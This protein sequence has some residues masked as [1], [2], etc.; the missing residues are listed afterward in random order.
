MI[1]LRVEKHIIKSN[2]RYYNLLND[3]CFKS[4]NLYN[5]ALYL[6][7]QFYFQNKKMIDFRTLENELRNDSIYDDYKQMPTVQSS[8]QLLRNLKSNI[9]SFFKSLNDYKK[10]PNKYNAMP[11][12]PKYKNK[13]GKNILVLT[14]QEVKLKDNIL[15]FPKSFNGFNI[16]TKIT[17]KNNYVSFQQ[18]RIIP[19][20]NHL[21]LE[22]VYRINTKEDIVDNKDNNKYLGI[23]IGIDNFATITNNINNHSFIINGKGLKSMNKYYNKL[24][25]HYQ[26]ICNTINNQ[27]TSKRINVL[28]LKRNNKIND[29]LYKASKYVIQY[30]L[31][32]NIKTIVIGQ[33]KHWKQ[34]S[35]MGK[36]INQT[37]VQI[38]FNRFIEMLQYKGKDN[39]INVI[40]TEESYT[41]GTSFLDNELPIKENYN[42]KRRIHRGLF[43]SNNNTLINADVNASYQ[44]IKKVFPNA[45]SKWNIG[46]VLSPINVSF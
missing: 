32:N 10:H 34:N 44:I 31:D 2:N 46:E 36:R 38:P 11:K 21:I 41:S 3:Y 40:V 8:Q 30:C 1:E 16:K 5:H 13:E 19:K 45:F 37:F 7:R 20:S 26:S 4:K 22:V 17:D 18:V 42:K 23:D 33:N 39:G 43:K 12:F 9:N 15:K 35:N 25:S 28:T 27:Y 24:K 29:Y 14:N 6:I